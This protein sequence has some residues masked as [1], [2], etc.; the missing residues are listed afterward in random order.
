MNYAI[1]ET[2]LS[3]QGEGIHAGRRAYFLRMFGCPVKCPWC[4]SVFAWNGKPREFADEGQLACRAKNSR[5]EIAV[6]TG[7]EP[8]AQNL[9][10]LVTALKGCGLAV[11]LETSGTLEIPEIDGARFDWVTVSP[12]LFKRPKKEALSRADEVKLIVCSVGEICQY[13]EIARE[14]ENAKAYWI[15]PEYSKSGDKEL[16]EGI[17]K[18][19]EENGGR[20]RA[21]WQIHKNFNAR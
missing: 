5:A 9:T 2:F 11:H 1:A 14:A 19:V 6:I 4:D 8:C 12:K 15:I 17:C 18:F 7:G 3:F 16:L 13:A 10:P 21:G 20:F